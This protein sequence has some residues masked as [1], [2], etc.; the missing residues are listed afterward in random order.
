MALQLGF[1][2]QVKIPILKIEAEEKGFPDEGI[3][4]KKTD[5]W[6]VLEHC[7][8]Y[9]AGKIQERIT[10]KMEK[11]NKTLFSILLP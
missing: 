10:T 9:K 2:E 6:T 4:S 11:K 3:P 8:G 7:V 1:E 5:K